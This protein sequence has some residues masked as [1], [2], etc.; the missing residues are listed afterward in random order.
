MEQQKRLDDV[1]RNLSNKIEPASNYR[2]KYNHLIGNS[3][4]KD[5]AKKTEANKSFGMG[6]IINWL[7]AVQVF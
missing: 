1:T 2:D 6:K 4:A 7:L 3:A 5:A